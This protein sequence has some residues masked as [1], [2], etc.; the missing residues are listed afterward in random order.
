[1]AKEI[2]IELDHPFKQGDKEITEVTL[3]KPNAGALRGLQL[4]MV[5]LMDVEQMNKLIPRISNLTERDL[6][7]IE[8]EDY[9]ALTTGVLSFFANAQDTL[10]T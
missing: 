6:L 1:M 10:S 9:T 2:T 5:L 4:S 3:R 7:N 8:I